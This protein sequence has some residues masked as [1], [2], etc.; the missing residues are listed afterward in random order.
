MHDCI[1]SDS[2]ALI[3]VCLLYFSVAVCNLSQPVVKM[4]SPSIL[5]SIALASVALL[6]Q[7]AAAQFSYPARV[8]QADS[9]PSSEQRETTRADINRDLDALL[10][11]IVVPPLMP[12]GGLGWRQVAYVNTTESGLCPSGWSLRSD[13]SERVVCGTNLDYRYAS[14]TFNTGGIPYDQVCGRIVGYQFGST[15]AFNHQNTDIDTLYV[16]GVSITHGSP[17]QHIWSFAA[18]RAEITAVEFDSICPCSM[19]STNGANIPTFVGN[20]YFCDTGTS[21]IMVKIFFYPD[22]PLWDGQGCGPS[23]TCCSFNSPPWF[24][25]QLPNA[26]TDG[27]EVR[28]GASDAR[29]HEDILLEF[30]VIYVR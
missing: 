3:C 23:S 11:D 20:N 19:N 5:I 18:G 15:E 27:I 24:N 17:R 16:D 9:C 25:V 22:D 7:P 26:T 28:I 4:E 6:A 30:L 10:Q 1:R 13:I 2:Q 12:C 21:P 29:R 8:Q 14:S